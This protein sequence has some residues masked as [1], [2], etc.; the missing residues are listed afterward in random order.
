[1]ILLNIHNK[2]DN[3]FI[4]H[5]YPYGFKRTD[6][7]YWIESTKRGDRFVSMTLNPKTNQWNKPKKSTYNAVMIMT[8]TLKEDKTFISYIGLYP[9]TDRE[10]II[11]FCDTIKDVV[12]NSLQTEQLKVLKAY[13]KAYENVT[14]RISG[15]SK[16][17]EEQKEINKEQDKIKEDINKSVN[18]HYQEGDF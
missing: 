15:D 9:T 18:H 8:K 16:T 4:V 17:E 6:I 1:M 7:K 3:A 14:Y 2:E 10:E 11:K 5:N 13:S 12:L